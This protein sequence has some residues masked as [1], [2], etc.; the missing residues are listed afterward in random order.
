MHANCD[1][2]VSALRSVELAK[3][4]KKKE[5]RLS[6]HCTFT[7][8]WSVKSRVGETFPQLA[9]VPRSPRGYVPYCLFAELHPSISAVICL[10][11][12]GGVRHMRCRNERNA[13][14]LCKAQQCAVWQRPALK[15]RWCSRCC[16]TEPASPSCCSPWCCGV[17]WCRGLRAQEKEK[18]QEMSVQGYR[19]GDV[20]KD[21]KA[22]KGCWTLRTNTVYESMFICFKKLLGLNW[23]F[24]DWM[25][26]SST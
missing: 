26:K 20:L 22:H 16:S 17:I 5:K 6:P 12:V 21:I 1:K 4:K 3:K 9:L 24:R 13:A 8:Y 25:L 18:N 19:I 11:P 23:Y 15:G 2:L 7:Y 14:E 10:P